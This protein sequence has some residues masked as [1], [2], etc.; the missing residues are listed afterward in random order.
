MNYLT[1]L[2]ARTTGFSLALAGAMVFSLGLSANAEPGEGGP[3]RGPGKMMKEADTNGD[4]GVSFEELKAVRPDATQERFDERDKNGDGILNREDR[5]EGPR[6]DRGRGPGGPG[7][8]GG[9]G[10]RGGDGPA[11]MLKEADTNEDGSVDFKEFQDFRMKTAQEH[12]DRIDS[13]GDGVLSTDDAMSAPRR[14]GGHG[15]GHDRRGGG[16]RGR[17]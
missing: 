9:H 2:N 8:D 14:K 17:S 10:H 6:G 11:K 7:R 16:K 13:N 15:K 12:F 4:G 3:H 1:R 5:P